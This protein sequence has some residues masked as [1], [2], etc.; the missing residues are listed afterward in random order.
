MV[1]STRVPDTVL[2]RL[3]KVPTPTLVDVLFERGYTRVYLEGV[4]P[5][6]PGARLAGRAVTLRFVPARPDIRQEVAQ[7]ERS[8]E[9]R[10]MELCG[11]GD[12]LVIDAMRMASS[13]VGGDIKFLGLKRRRAEGIVTDGALRD[14]P[15]LKDYHLK[16]FAAGVTAKTGPWEFFPWGVNEVVQC[17]GGAVRPG[18]VIIGDDAGV[19]VVPQALA[20]EVA[21]AAEAHEELEAWIKE[22]VERENVSPGRYYPIQEETRRLFQE[23]RR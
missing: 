1:Q 22:R 19:V 2:E 5:L 3:R 7:R 12:V 8:P 21:A 6:T 17:G 9:Y 18:D 4:R 10:A 14:V 11:P 23:S 15:T 13:S 20:E 16:L